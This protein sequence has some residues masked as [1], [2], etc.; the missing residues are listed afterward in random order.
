MYVG[1]EN[2]LSTLARACM[3]VGASCRVIA[4]EMDPQNCEEVVEW[5]R[6]ILDPQCSVDE[7]AACHQ[8]SG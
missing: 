2:P 7:R 6:K 3:C 5:V 4:L 1:G 8:V